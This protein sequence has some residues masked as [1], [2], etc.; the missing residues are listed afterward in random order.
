SKIPENYRNADGYWTGV[1]VGVL[2]FCSNQTKLNSVGVPVPASWNAL[3]DPKLSKNIGTA[4]PSTSGTA[5][6]TLWTQVTLN[7]GDQDKALD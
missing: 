3:L 5:F 1:Y 2:G 7:N 6:T 4:H